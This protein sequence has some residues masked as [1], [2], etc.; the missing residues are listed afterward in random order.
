MCGAAQ[1]SRAGSCERMEGEGEKV[2][3]GETGFRDE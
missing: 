3:K 1:S 2:D